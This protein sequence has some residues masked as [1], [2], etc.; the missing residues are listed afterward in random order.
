VTVILKENKTNYCRSLEYRGYLKT[1]VRFLPIK[2]DFVDENGGHTVLGQEPLNYDGGNRWGT[3][4]TAKLEFNSS[5]GYL[6]MRVIENHEYLFDLETSKGG[7]SFFQDGIFITQVDN[8]LP[9]S[10]GKYVVGRL[11]LVGDDKC[12]LSMDRNRLLWGKDQFARVKK[13]VL[14]G[15][16]TIANRLLEIS[17]RQAPPENVHRNLIQKLGSFFD[18]NEVDDI[19]YDH[20]NTELRTGVEG[21]FRMF[22]RIHHSRYDMLHNPTTTSLNAHGYITN[23]QQAVIEGLKKR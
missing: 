13:R 23:W 7:V 5:E 12:R 8:L 9:E 3:E 1:N 14:Y 11:N 15:L 16:V 10:A 18:F 19:I 20:L 6:L 4:L 2:I 21:Q 17:N 22:I